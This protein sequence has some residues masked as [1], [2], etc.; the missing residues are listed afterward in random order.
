MYQNVKDDIVDEASIK[1]MVDTFYGKVRQDALIGPVFDAVVHDW[2]EHLPTMYAFW[3]NLIF[4]RGDYRGN[5]FAKH[6]SLDVGREHF[7]RW[8]Q[9]FEA[10]VAELFRGPVS[11]QALNAAKSIAHSFQV[12]KGIDPF[13]A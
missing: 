4:R 6:A 2:D 7:V 9:L 3:T 11:E 10:T 12:R 1:L 13:S 8:L 5:P